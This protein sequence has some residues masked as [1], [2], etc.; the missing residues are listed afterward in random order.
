MKKSALKTSN[1]FYFFLNLCLFNNILA[2]QRNTPRTPL[3]LQFASAKLRQ[4]CRTHC[5]MILWKRVCQ[6]SHAFR[7]AGRQTGWVMMFCCYLLMGAPRQLWQGGHVYEVDLPPEV[8]VATD[9]PNLCANKQAK[10]ILIHVLISEHDKSAFLSRI[11]NCPYLL[12]LRFSQLWRRVVRL[13]NNLPPLLSGSKQQEA[14]QG[15]INLRMTCSD[16][17]VGRIATYYYV[18]HKF[19]YVLE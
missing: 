5:M 6:G 1:P 3:S 4:E 17:Y 11:R 13:R 14:K 16:I 10:K 9:C 7:Q 8:T 2:N 15:N 19:I 12:D 18:Y